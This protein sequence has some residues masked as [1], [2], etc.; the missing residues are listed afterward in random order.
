VHFARRGQQFTDVFLE[1][2]AR[3][4]SSGEIWEEAWNDA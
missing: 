1:G 2:D 3:M 4:V